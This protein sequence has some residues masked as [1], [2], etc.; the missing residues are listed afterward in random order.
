MASVK[1]KVDVVNAKGETSRAS[2][3]KG[4]ERGDKLVVGANS[5]ATVYFSD[6]NVIELSEKSTVTVGGKV[7]AK[8]HPGS[9]DIPGGVYAQVS[10]VVT[11][12]SRQS[13]LVGLSQMRG[14][15]ERAPLIQSPRNTDLLEDRPTLQWRK[16][17]GATRYHVTVSGDNGTIWTRDATGAS[18]AYPADV[19]ALPRDADYLWALEVFSDKGPLAREESVFHVMS[20][21]SAGTVREDVGRIRES[22][23]GDASAAS[24]FLSGS[25]LMGKGL[26][27]DAAEQFEVLCKLSPDASAPHEALGNAYRAMGLMDQAAAEYQIA[28]ELSRTP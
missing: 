21:A 23:G 4:L 6:G 16:I 22:A 18:L 10:K 20:A 13:G 11:G 9:P 12:G 24:A 27:R 19:V 1:G 7:A 25:Y 8:S 15:D 28:L 17:E 26:Y 5:A 2:F 3:G 14:A